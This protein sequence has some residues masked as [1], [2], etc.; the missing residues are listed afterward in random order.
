[1]AC[2]ILPSLTEQTARPHSSRQRICPTATTSRHLSVATFRLV[3][4]SQKSMSAWWNN[5]SLCLSM[6]SKWRWILQ[7]LCS[8]GKT[9][10]T[11]RLTFGWMLT[12]SSWLVVGTPT[13]GLPTHPGM[14]TRNFTKASST[15]HSASRSQRS[16]W[17]CKKELQPI[18]R[19][20]A[21]NADELFT[22]SFSHA[23]PTIPIQHHPRPLP[24]NRCRQHRAITIL[25]LRYMKQII[26]TRWRN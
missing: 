15:M 16:L 21:D 10:S 6:G 4:G 25:K 23:H 1:M 26:T 3:Y 11:C 19:C 8:S 9:P 20:R 14:S 5:G 2:I 17:L 24:W 12:H 18:Q 22:R 7:C 13:P